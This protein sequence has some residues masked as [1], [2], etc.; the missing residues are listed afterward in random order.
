MNKQATFY[1]IQQSVT[2]VLWGS[3]ACLPAHL[4]AHPPACL[5]T[6]LLA[7]LP[8]YLP[9]ACPTPHP[10]A[11]AFRQLPLLTQYVE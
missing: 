1:I 3:W 11:R 10:G 4:P 2:H 5:P 6:C 7:H 9:P 8:T